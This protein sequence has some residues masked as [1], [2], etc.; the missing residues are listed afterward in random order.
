MGDQVTR[1][2][3]E[4][5]DTEKATWKQGSKSVVKNHADYGESTQPLDLTPM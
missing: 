1:Y 2:Q 5:I 3:K 4:D